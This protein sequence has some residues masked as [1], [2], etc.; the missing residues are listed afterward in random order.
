MS[1][2]G[3]R[4][5]SAATYWRALGCA[6]KFG[7]TS[8]RVG[9]VSAP[10]FDLPAAGEAGRAAGRPE[11]PHGAVLQLRFGWWHGAYEPERGPNSFGRT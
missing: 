10:A 6:R 2:V 3:I 1:A 11:Q 7:A 9:V 8:D 4:R 5:P